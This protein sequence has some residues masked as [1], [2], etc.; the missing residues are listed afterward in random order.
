MIAFMRCVLL[1]ACI[2]FLDFSLFLLALFSLMIRLK[3]GRHSTS[4]PRAITYSNAMNSP[5]V[6]SIC[7]PIIGVAPPSS[8]RQLPGHGLEEHA[9]GAATIHPA[10]PPCAWWSADSPPPPASD[11]SA[12]VA[13]AAVCVADRLRRGSVASAAVC[14]ADRSPGDPGHRR[15]RPPPCPTGPACLVD[16]DSELARAL[17]AD[18]FH[19]DWPHW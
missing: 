10:L 13:S 12:H 9:D 7:P 4:L 5:Q 11:A 17:A 6:Y 15:Y 14:V 16:A 2:L 8:H 18:P 1:K 3:Q 19:L